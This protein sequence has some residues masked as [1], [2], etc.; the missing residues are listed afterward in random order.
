MILENDKNLWVYYVI[1]LSFHGFFFGRHKQV[2][3]LHLNIL[4]YFNK[5]ITYTK[6]I[7]II[8]KLDILPLS[9]K[10]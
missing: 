1:R 2:V 9:H 10:T 4:K 8:R 7:V 3:Q 6:E 5:T